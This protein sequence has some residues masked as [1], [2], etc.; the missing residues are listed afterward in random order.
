MLTPNE[1]R[2]MTGDE[3]LRKVADLKK[4][5]YNLR[6]EAKSGRIEKPHKIRLTRRDIA[7]C[8]TILKEMERAGSKRTDDAGTGTE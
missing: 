3:I 1:I 4:E 7:R 6:V 2:N 5:L 8:E